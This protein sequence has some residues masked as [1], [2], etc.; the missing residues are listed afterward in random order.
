MALI[1]FSLFSRKKKDDNDSGEKIPAK[2][3]ERTTNGKTIYFFQYEET[4]ILCSSS[5]MMIIKLFPFFSSSHSHLYI[6][7][8]FVYFLHNAKYGIRNSP[9]KLPEGVR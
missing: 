5:T 9:Y 7:L 3:K 8:S 6:A 4:I 1:R 2:M